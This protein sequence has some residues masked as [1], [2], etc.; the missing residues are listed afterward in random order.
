MNTDG[1]KDSHQTIPSLRKNKYLRETQVTKKKLKAIKACTPK[2]TQKIS[3][4]GWKKDHF[5][6]SQNEPNSSS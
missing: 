3:F 5:R 4:H 1:L 6:T 2:N